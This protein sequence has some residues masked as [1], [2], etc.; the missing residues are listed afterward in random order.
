[1]PTAW[2]YTV[3]K[4]AS[5]EDLAKLLLGDRRRWQA[6]SVF[7]KLGRQRRIK[8]GRKLVVPFTVPHLVVAG[9]TWADLAK[10]YHGQ[11]KSTGLLASHN[12]SRSYKPAPGAQV[13]IPIGDVRID[14]LRLE[15]LLNERLLGVTGEPEREKREILQEANA[16]LRQGEYWAVPLR[17]IQLLAREIPSDDYAA[18]IFKLLAVAYVAV[19]RIELAVRAFS[20]ALRRQPTMPLDQVATSP[21]V[22]RAFVEAKAKLQAGGL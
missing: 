20:E 10:R 16:L 14:P 1:V 21:K 11:Q 3:R 7:N 12:F 2:T 6:L 4:A 13:E 22:I 17:L 9:D 18:E 19:D 15:D 8:T 5:V